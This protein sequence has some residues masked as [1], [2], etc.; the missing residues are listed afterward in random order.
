MIA[1]KKVKMIITAL[2]VLIL[3]GLLELLNF[4]LTG[5]MMKPIVG[6]DLI[7]KYSVSLPDEGKEFLELMPDGIC[8]Q[9]IF[10]KD[11]RSYH[12]SGQW[13]F[14]H[15]SLNHDQLVLIGTHY[16]LSEFGDKLNPDIGQIEKNTATLLPTER[17]L[18]GNIK[19]E[20]YGDQGIYY[21]KID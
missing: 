8:K 9:D 2:G 18:M 10:L 7:G 4:A 3:C 12:T 15:A 21:R 1:M 16:S 20:L 11:G 5:P 14:R 17:T 6:E 13:Q 19:I